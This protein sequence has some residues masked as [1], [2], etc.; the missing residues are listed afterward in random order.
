MMTLMAYEARRAR[1]ELAFERLVEITT[2]VE[3]GQRIPDGLLLELIA[4][5]ADLPHLPAE[6]HVHLLQLDLRPLALGDVAQGDQAAVL[7]AAV[8]A[9]ETTETS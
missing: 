9:A 6:A 4:Q 7:P 8:I 2:V 5:G 3:A 1:A